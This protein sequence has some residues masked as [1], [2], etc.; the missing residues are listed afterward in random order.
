MPGAFDQIFRAAFTP[1]RWQTNVSDWIF[2]VTRLGSLGVWWGSEN[3]SDMSLKFPVSH[4]HSNLRGGRGGDLAPPLPQGILRLQAVWRV[5][6]VWRVCLRW[7]QIV[8]DWFSMWL[9]VVFLFLTPDQTVNPVNQTVRLC[10]LD[11]AGISLALSGA[12][13]ILVLRDAHA[14]VNGIQRL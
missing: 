2:V 7:I 6:K 13:Q 3:M 4:G 1:G 9:W 14:S 5:W 12:G 10:Q 11:F 8:S